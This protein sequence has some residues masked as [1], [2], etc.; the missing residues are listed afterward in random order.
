[1]YIFNFALQLQWNTEFDPYTSYLQR[2]TV[3][4]FRKANP[5][6]ESA[7]SKCS[8]GEENARIKYAASCMEGFLDAMEEAVSNIEVLFQSE[9][10]HSSEEDDDSPR[11]SIVY[12]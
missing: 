2:T 4:D 11:V 1:M 3:Q 5:A 12:G 8:A 9:K 7:T 6:M 10:D